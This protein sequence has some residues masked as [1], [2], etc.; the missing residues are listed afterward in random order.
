MNRFKIILSLLSII[1]TLV[2]QSQEITY[3]QESIYFPDQI[4]IAKFKKGYTKNDPSVPSKY[5]EITEMK[6]F[7]GGEGYISIKNIDPKILLSNNKK[8]IYIPAGSYLIVEFRNGL[9]NFQDNFNLII[10]SCTKCSCGKQ[11]IDSALISISSNKNNFIPLGVIHSYETRGFN[12]EKY[13][14]NQNIKYVKIEGLSSTSHPYGFE[15]MKIFGFKDNTLIEEAND[16]PIINNRNKNLPLQVITIPD[17][18]FDLNDST[19]KAEQS[20]IIDSICIDLKNRRLEKLNVF[21]YTDAS[22]DTKYNKR[23]SEARARSVLNRLLNSGIDG[24]IIEIDGFGESKLLP[25]LDSLDSRNR[26]V[27]IVIKETVYEP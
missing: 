26:R 27:E 6:Y 11:T 24:S 5:R 17:I 4:T 21:G 25:G 15:L 20:F 16:A 1:S 13:N 19:L 3:N 12:I 18:F 10:M 23:L 22:G 8:Y 2:T 14:V 7:F 9:K